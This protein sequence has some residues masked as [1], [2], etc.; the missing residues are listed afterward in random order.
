MNK[1]KE[2]IRKVLPVVLIIL[3]VAYGLYNDYYLINNKIDDSAEISDVQQTDSDVKS[4]S[5]TKTELSNSKSNVAADGK[6]EDSNKPSTTGT[7][8]NNNENKTNNSST[9]GNNKPST[10]NSGSGNNSGNSGSSGNNTGCTWVDKKV[11]VSE[12]HYEQRLV[13]AAW[14]EWIETKAAW[15]EEDTYCYAWG[16]D[17]VEV[18]IC[19]GCGAV[20]Y[21]G[22]EANSHRN[23]D[24]PACGGWHNDYIDV[25]EPHCK[26]WK[27]EYINHPAE[28]YYQNHP[29][30]YESVW[31]DAVYKTERVC[32]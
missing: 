28:G 7:A 12:G 31:V 11:L 3:S 19:N 30:E 8:A 5:K 25:G 15:T 24:N 13:K 20:F 10:N 18:Y 17:R 23:P 16:Q 9:T 27:T 2:I 26:E 1:I 4:G 14:S 6:N 22:S 32:E 29:A 21:S